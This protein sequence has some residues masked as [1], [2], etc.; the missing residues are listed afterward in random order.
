MGAVV[1]LVCPITGISPLS[2][3]AK[4]FSLFLLERVAAVCLDDAISK[5]ILVAIGI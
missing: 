5:P 2:G 3:Y 1:F 4:I